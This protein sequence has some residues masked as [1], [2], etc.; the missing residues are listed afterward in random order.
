VNI[1]IDTSALAKRY[2][3]EPGSEEL[4]DLFLSVAT[5]VFVSTLA[6][7][8]F[9]AALGR[10]VRDGE[11]LREPAAIALRELEKD[12]QALFIRIPL[13]EEIAESAATLATQHPLKGADAA[14]LAT[15]MATG[16]SVFVAS[17]QELV[18]A[19]KKAGLEPYD[20]SAGSFR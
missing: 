3:Q 11:I 5:R 9:A 4:D 10:K 13:T 18:R 15:A 19:S 16:V 1:F 20:P 12:W 17:D 14:H 6:L 7:P 2:I 8:E